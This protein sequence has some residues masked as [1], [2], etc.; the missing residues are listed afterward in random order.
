MDVPKLPSNP[1]TISDLRLKANKWTPESVRL[2]YASKPLDGEVVAQIRR[3]LEELASWDNYERR[4]S[5]TREAVKLA[6]Q[7]LLAPHEPVN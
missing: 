6:L 7:R 1:S 5:E 3:D 4:T 2:K